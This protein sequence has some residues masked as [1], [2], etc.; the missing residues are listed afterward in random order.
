MRLVVAVAGL[1]F[2]AAPASAQYYYG[3]RP[4]VPVGPSSAY[5]AAE[6]VQAMGLEPMG[7][8]SRSGPFFIQN[9]RDDFGRVLRVT[10]DARRSQVVAVEAGVPPRGV[11]GPQAGYPPYRYPAPGYAMRAPGDL[12]LAPPGSIM[13]GRA[14]PQ[15]AVAPPRPASVTPHIPTA[16][17]AATPKPATRAASATPMPRKRPAAAPQ[18]AVGSVEPMPAQ[19]AAPP[20]PAQPSAVTP[21]TPLE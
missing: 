13:D 2:V 20:T 15:H 12:A 19:N 17:Q 3:P 6:I 11:Y 9:A 4:A 18:E 10:V 7:P 1:M 21:V 8:A 14:Q 5:D 16:P